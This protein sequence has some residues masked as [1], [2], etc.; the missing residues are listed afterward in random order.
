M[1][2]KALGLLPQFYQSEEWGEQPC[3]A[4]ERKLV[5]LL[6]RIQIQPLKWCLTSWDACNMGESDIKQ[7]REEPQKGKVEMQS[8]QPHPAE[9]GL[10]ITWGS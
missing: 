7:H 3:V 6:T 8:E 5:V 4:F 1:G 9:M 10:K 2:H